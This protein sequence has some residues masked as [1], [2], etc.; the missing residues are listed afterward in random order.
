MTKPVPWSEVF[1]GRQHELELLDQA[2]EAVGGESPVPQ[3]VALVGDSG[4]GK[5]RIVQEFFSRLSTKVDGEGADGYWPDRLARENENLR[6]NPDPADCNGDRPMRFLWWAVRMPDPTGRNAARGGVASSVDVLRAH[7]EPFAA[8]R[9]RAALRKQIVRDIGFD[10]ATEVANT[11]SFGLVGIARAVYGHAQSAWK[12]ETGSRI[13]IGPQAH[14][15]SS[16]TSLKDTIVDDFR[17]LFSERGDKA[18]RLP[19]IL[20]VDDAQWA[21]LDPLT[22][23]TVSE[24]I[25]LARAEGWPLLTVVTYWERE[26]REHCAGADETLAAKLAADGERPD[27]HVAM[28][29]PELDLGAMVAAGLPG[30]THEQRS[31]ILE[32]AGGNPRLLDEILRHLLRRPR[33]FLNR[34]PARALTPAAESDLATREF[35]LH[36]LIYQRLSSADLDTRMSLGLASA[37]GTRFCKRLLS[38]PGPEADGEISLEAG[39]EKAIDPYAMIQLVQDGIGEFAQRIYWEVAREQANDLMDV[40]EVEDALREALRR[41]DDLKQSFFADFSHEEKLLACRLATSLFSDS[42]EGD[43]LARRLRSL[44]YLAMTAARL[45][46]VQAFVRDAGALVDCARANFALGGELEV[47][48]LTPVIDRALG[49]NALEIADALLDL[50]ERDVRRAGG[51][52]VDVRR[53]ILDI[54][55][56]Q[57]AVYRQGGAARDEAVATLRRWFGGPDDIATPDASCAFVELAKLLVFDLPYSLGVADVDRLEGLL[58][59]LHPHTAR[60]VPDDLD[61]LIAG[62]LLLRLEGASLTEARMLADDYEALWM[63]LV[64]QAP[65]LDDVPPDA[66]GRW[67]QTLTESPRHWLA[68][69][70]ERIREAEDDRFL[71]SLS[72]R[73][74]LFRQL[75]VAAAHFDFRANFGPDR[76]IYFYAIDAQKAFPDELIYL[77]EIDA[78]LICFSGARIIVAERFEILGNLKEV[79]AVGYVLWDDSS[80]QKFIDGKIVPVRTLTVNDMLS[81]PAYRSSAPAPVEPSAAEVLDFPTGKP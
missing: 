16:Q 24:L 31:L 34:D 15:Q 7:L 33:H 49:L 8:A 41:H 30:T 9:V 43:D 45:N 26:W 77:P 56:A 80:K 20:F 65:D 6:I 4:L 29:R 25:A 57:L 18:A 11:F 60:L 75:P 12:N 36:D 78:C 52:D 1:C 27:L 37:Q 22:L 39:L 17:T 28:L 74:A 64:R 3:V 5:T 61:L 54:R 48:N 62:L 70:L 50:D 40:A 73:A 23:D 13:Q 71:G 59:A 2:W 19:A 14:L 67:P 66:C 38:S 58:H 10:V 63:R 35:D 53:R 21:H 79:G 69:V 55:K 81:D 51:E 44:W 72:R 32:K 46:D 47:V 42:D 68:S 76:V